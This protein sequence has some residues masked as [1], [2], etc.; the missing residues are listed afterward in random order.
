MS[1]R[2]MG[3]KGNEALITFEGNEIPSVIL[4]Y[5]GVKR[6]FPYIPKAVNRSRYHKI[7]HK[8][9]VCPNPER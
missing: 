1:A 4:F 8:F 9:D 2:R 3:A 5:S 6:V 7:G